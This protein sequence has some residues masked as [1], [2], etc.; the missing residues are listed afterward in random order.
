MNHD[1]DHGRLF[2]SLAAYVLG[3]LTEQERVEVEDHLDVC[4]VCSSEYADLA[5]AGMI[6]ALNVPPR[7]PPARL[8]SMLLQR[9]DDEPAPSELPLEYIEDHEV[10]R[11]RIAR[12]GVMALRPRFRYATA[13]VLAVG[14]FTAS[15]TIVLNNSSLDERVNMLESQAAMEATA[16]SAIASSMGN[17]AEV[18]DEPESTLE[19]VSRLAKGVESLQEILRESVGLMEDAA[20]PEIRTAFLESADGADGPVGSL[21]ANNADA[22]SGVL[23]ISGMEPSPPGY[24]Y[25]LWLNIGGVTRSIITFRVDAMGNALVKLPIPFMPT[26]P[27]G[28]VTLEP[29]FGS[30]SPTGTE[31]LR[32]SGP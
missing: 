2:D 30:V 4:A 22:N 3:A 31:I 28:A 24:V 20:D 17:E 27:V 7:E 6:L 14:V 23:L 25:Q 29:G 13:A 15:I 10:E 1:N 5:E 19:T 32:V 12:L 16:V 9:V 18:V 8:K 26:I 11:S 21:V